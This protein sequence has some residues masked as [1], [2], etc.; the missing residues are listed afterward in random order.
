MKRVNYYILLGI[1]FLLTS[2]SR[3]SMMKLVT[4]TP[5]IEYNKPNNFD[6]LNKYQKDVVYLTELI[7]Q[8][9]P[10]LNSKISIN[11][12]NLLSKQLLSKTSEINNDFEF[13]ILIHK[14]MALLE[15]GHST[16]I[17]EYP[18][19]S[20][21]HYFLYKEKD[22]WIIGNVDKSIDSNVIGSKV[23]YI[24]NI[25]INDIEKKINSFQCGENSYLRYQR[26]LQWPVVE[27][28]Y[29]KAIGVCNN[30]F[31][32]EFIT[33]KNDKKYRFTI[34]PSKDFQE[35]NIKIKKSKYNF[36]KQQNNGF[37][38]K[39]DSINSYAYLQMNTSLDYVSIK[40][41]INN[42]TNFLTRPI[43]LWYLKKQ[44]QDAKNFGVLLQSL[45]REI[46]EKNI[47]SLIVD[48]RNNTGG[49]ENTGKQ[50]I[51]YLTNNQNIKGFSNY[52]QVSPYL[53]QQV[54]DVYK[55][56]NKLYKEKYNKSLPFKEINVTREFENKPYFYSITNDKSPYLLDST[57]SKFNGKVYVL[58]GTKTFSAGQLLATTLSDN[59]LATVVGQPTG[60]KPTTQTGAS[61]FKLPNTK[62]IVYISY[63]FLERPNTKK[64]EEKALFPD[65]ELFT[66]YEEY[67]NGIDIS[68]EYIMNEIIK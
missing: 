35:Y 19:G 39:T 5:N 43:V 31:N 27:P 46:E 4:K 56:Y 67:I 47:K 64:N 33:I 49:D 37:Y 6:S 52:L 57:I 12:Y 62:L 7:K 29:W 26:F 18:K 30:N 59:N 51:W 50:L 11:D 38:Y 17:I 10:R 41:G 32:L 1:I 23:L 36:T 55:G 68:F 2:C 25:S 13:E 63:S 9:Y 44:T 66:T 53:K 8:T 15:D 21:Y 16:S 48:L 20:K 14:F 45:F 24:N 3:Y 54:K 61:G 34:K 65:V 60:N 28:N 58:V 40:N 42:Y 22:N